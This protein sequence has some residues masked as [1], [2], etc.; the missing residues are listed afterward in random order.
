MKTNATSIGPNFILKTTWFK[1][2]APSF[3]SYFTTSQLE[4]Q[5]QKLN[6][7]YP[8]CNATELKVIDQWNLNDIATIHCKSVLSSN[9]L[10]NGLK[11]N[12][13]AINKTS[14]NYISNVVIVTPLST[15]CQVESTVAEYGLGGISRINTNNKGVFI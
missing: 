4:P 11:G 13:C 9:C 10:Q 8:A 5:T 15:G 1:Q 14:T 2:A 12:F 3:N 7:T 6:I